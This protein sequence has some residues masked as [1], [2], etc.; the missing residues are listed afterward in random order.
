MH[1]GMFDVQLLRTFLAVS[2]ALQ[3][4]A[5][6]ARLG[7]SQSTVSQ[8]IRR[9]EAVC[10]RQLVVRDTHSVS[11]TADGSVLADLAHGIIDL[12]KQA[13]DYFSDTAP[14]GRVRLGVSDDLA[15]TR[16][17][18]LLRNLLE[19]EP[20]LSIELTIGLTGTLYQKLDTG[21]I[22]LIFAKRPLNDTRGEVVWREKLIWMAHRDFRLGADEAVPLIMYPGSSITS[23]LA[24]D[25][26]NR[27][28][29]AWYIACSSETL[30]GLWAGARAGL[31]VMAQSRLLIEAPHAELVEVPTLAL[32]PELGEVDFVVL[33]RSAKLSGA[34]STLASLIAEKGPDL[35]RHRPLLTAGIAL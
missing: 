21:R 30:A 26:L 17:P 23:T 14:R 24:L 16:F 15:T 1:D 4:T 19:L 9:L 29:R 10:G 11:L 5:A 13:A 3:F 22:D 32:L 7:L 28:R 20:M 12:N 31:G 27:S 6:G 2:E 33:G 35:W 18:D 8:H 34:I 25:A